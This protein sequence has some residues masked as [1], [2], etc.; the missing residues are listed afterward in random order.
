MS[1]TLRQMGESDRALWIALRGQLW[2]EYMADHPAA[3]AKARGF[4]ELCSDALLDNTHSQA[5]HAG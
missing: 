1:S 3:F 5:A 2:P 4:T